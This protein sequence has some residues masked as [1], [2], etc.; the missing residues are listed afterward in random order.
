MA[1]PTLT[2]SYNAFDTSVDSASL[3]TASFTPAAGDVIVVKALSSD[4]SM[5]FGT[6]TG[7]GLT[8]TSQYSLFTAL[9]T[10]IQ[11]W[12]AVVGGSPSSMTVTLSVAGTAHTHGMVV[13]RWA[14]ATLAG[15]PATGHAQSASGTP[16]AT[17]TTVGTNSVVSWVSGD[18]NEILG[19]RTYLGTG[20][21]VAS[22]QA[23][24]HYVG[25]WAY[26]P[27]AA[28]GSQTFG[29]SA[30]AGQKWTLAGIEILQGTNPV[31]DAD[32]GSGADTGSVTHRT[33]SDAEIGSGFDSGGSF[34]QAGP[35]E[36]VAD[37]GTGAE[38]AAIGITSADTGSGLDAGTVATPGIPITDSDQSRRPPGF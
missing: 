25:D 36:P 4:A 30:P 13:E 24:T 33:V 16:S 26:Q 6:P 9:F 1:G 35:Y 5:T 2:Q 20:I 10:G 21:E 38:A 37:T 19:A 8:Y 31:T 28:A 34:T 18:W 14:G 11:I 29:L 22:Q 27:A 15:T 32:T 12:T 17:V 7:G 3:V 23:D